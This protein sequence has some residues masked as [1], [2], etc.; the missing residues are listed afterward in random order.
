MTEKSHEK[1]IEHK[2][3][4]PQ[5]PT[6]AELAEEFRQDDEVAGYDIRDTPA[7]RKLRRAITLG[8]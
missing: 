6:L 4:Q 7:L 2:N 5:R 1:V 8:P 3:S